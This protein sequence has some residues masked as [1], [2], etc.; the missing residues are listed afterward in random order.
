MYLSYY[1]LKIKPFQL[2]PDPSFFFSSKGHKRAMAYL[3]Y[4]LSQEDGFIIVTGE[5]GAGKTTLMRHLF[6]RL[7]KDQ[8]IAAQL[9]NTHLE[10]DDILRMVAAAFG[11]PHL[12]ATKA[13]LLLEIEQFLRQS[14]KQGKRV[15]LLVDEAQNLSTSALEELRM[16]SNFQTDDKLLLQTFLLGQPEFRKTLLGSG[17]QQ[18]RQRVIATYHLGP[19]DATE[20]KSYIEH[21]LITAGWSGDPLIRDDAFDAIYSF[22]GGIPRKINT[23]CDRL[24]IMGCLEELHTIGQEEVNVVIQDIQQEFDLPVNTDLG[25]DELNTH[26]V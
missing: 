11:L 23:L 6:Q 12:N 8:F 15:L 24:L 19:L 16:L 25:P 1:G 10:A 18:L 2:K 26:T 21:R 17:M 4:G 7:E 20:T 22:T 13:T 14:D 9:V 5:V 3:E